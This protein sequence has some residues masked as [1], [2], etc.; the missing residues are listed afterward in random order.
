LSLVMVS[1]RRKIFELV[2]ARYNLKKF[3]KH[4]K[5]FSTH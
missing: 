4:Q 3:E 2:G 1:S 5:C